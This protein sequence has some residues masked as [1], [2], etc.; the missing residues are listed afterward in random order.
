M[1]KKFHVK[2]LLLSIVLLASNACS[3]GSSPGQTPG[4]GGEGGAGIANG[5]DDGELFAPFPGITP[6]ELLTPAAGVGQKPLFEWTPVKGA[7]RFALFLQFPDG[8]PYWAW[9]G[10]DSS[11][12]LG[13]LE[14]PPPEDAAG[15]ILL[16]DMAWAVLAFDAEGNVIA[17]SVLQS[18]SP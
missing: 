2:L 15:P 12:Y 16:E 10:A 11:I 8:E 18:I 14:S 13:G 9:S 6:I 17:S 4:G 1:I 3:G 7:A 5:A